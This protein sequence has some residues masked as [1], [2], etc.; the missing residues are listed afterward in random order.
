MAGGPG[1]ILS[2]ETI[3]DVAKHALKPGGFECDW[4][5]GKS[6]GKPKTCQVVLGSWDLLRKVCVLS[7]WHAVFLTWSCCAYFLSNLLSIFPCSVSVL[8]R[9]GFKNIFELTLYFS[10]IYTPTVV[11]RENRFVTHTF[12]Y[13]SQYLFEFFGS[14]ILGF[15]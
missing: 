14:R 1:V 12:L 6:G 4:D 8:C 13:L 9:T 11:F 10:S 3:R 5:I 2:P 7:F 15:R